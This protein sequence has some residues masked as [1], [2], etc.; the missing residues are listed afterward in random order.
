M[1]SATQSLPAEVGGQGRLA[2]VWGSGLMIIV[3]VC[4]GAG[5]ALSAALKS[6]QGSFAI[7]GVGTP[8]VTVVTIAKKGLKAC[9]ERLSVK[10]LRS[11]E[12]WRQGVRSLRWSLL[13]GSQKKAVLLLA[14]TS[15]LINLGG[16]VAVRELGSGMNASFSTAGGLLAGALALRFAPQWLARGVVL[17]AVVFAAISAGHGNFTIFGLVAA[18]CAASHMFNLPKQIVV[19]GEKRDEGLTWANL[20]S[21]PFVLPG[22]F[23]WDH[24]QGVSW[25]WGGKEIFG[26]VCAGLLVMVIPIFLQ[27]AAEARGMKEQDMGALASLS[28]PLHALVGLVLSPVTLALT[29][30]AA[31]LP[32]F[33]QWGFFAIVAGTAVAVPFM[34]KDNSWKRAQSEPVAAQP[35]FVA[36]QSEFDGT[37]GGRIWET[38]EPEPLTGPVSPL[39]QLGTPVPGAFG[40]APE[41]QYVEAEPS[42]SLGGGSFD[43]DTGEAVLMS[44]GSVVFTGVNGLTV[45]VDGEYK[46]EAK[47]LS[48]GS[49]IEGLFT[50]TEVIDGTVSNGVHTVKVPRGAVTANPH[51]GTISIKKKSQGES[52]LGAASVE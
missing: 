38:R 19:L 30:K 16:P 14:L 20:I 47:G 25:A 41:E 49:L 18:L 52:T 4:Q 3:V 40:L 36:A 46:I 23:L 44:D 31:V 39:A 22:T 27:N 15:A 50:G 6:F 34:P 8:I 21:A 12:V 42:T 11:P 43:W 24:F 33:S 1:S 37:T 32:T 35:E 26:A 17:T 28:S 51:T 5:L 45:E 9:D 2:K 10:A 29:G 7:V 48:G 13:S